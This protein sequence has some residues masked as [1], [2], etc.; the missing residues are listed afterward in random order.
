MILAPL[1]GIALDWSTGNGAGGSFWP[2]GA[3]GLIISLALFT[4]ALMRRDP[5]AST[6]AHSNDPD[7]DPLPIQV[8]GN[9][10]YLDPGEASIDFTLPSIRR[11]ELTGDYIEAPLTLSDHLGKIVWFQV[12]GHW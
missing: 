1:L 2:L 6:F 7:E 3:A 12:Y 10:T 8:F 5:S 9:T 4:R 11:D